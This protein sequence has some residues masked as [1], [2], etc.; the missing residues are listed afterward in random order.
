MPFSIANSRTL[1]AQWD[2]VLIR[3]CQAHKRSHQRL[4]QG[5]PVFTSRAKGAHFWDADGNRYLDY[6][7]GFGP[8]LLGYDDSVVNAAIVGQLAR[9]TIYSTAHSLEIETAKRILEFNPW[10]GM[11][12]FFIGGSATTTVAVRIARAYTEQSKIVRSGY[13]GWHDW[14]QPGGA[15]VPPRR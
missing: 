15:G 4:E 1:L 14:T 2:S 5:Y 8:I 6:L 11:V 10:A 7:M 13:H 3:G 12:G 9:G